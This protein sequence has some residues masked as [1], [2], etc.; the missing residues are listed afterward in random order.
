[1]GVV[2]PYV[3]QATATQAALRN[4]FPPTFECG[5]AHQFQ[6]R[7]FDH[8][9]FDL[10]EPVGHRGWMFGAK[11]TSENPYNR[12]G[13]RLFNVAS[14]RA[15]EVVFIIADM[16]VVRAAREGSALAALLR[17]I[18]NGDACVKPASWLLR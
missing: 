16:R 13:A 2:V 14:T 18:E 6:G 9:V 10:V 12:S 7:E 3:P 11:R 15:R 1:M 4:H 5:T 17:L 8:V